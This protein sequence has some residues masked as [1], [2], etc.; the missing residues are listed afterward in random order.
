MFKANRNTQTNATIGNIDKDK[1]LLLEIIK[2]SGENRN[3]KPIYRFQD[4]Y[5]G[6]R[7]HKKKYLRHFH[8]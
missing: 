5:S 6:F 1:F 2:M 4:K 3:G 7:T 8:I